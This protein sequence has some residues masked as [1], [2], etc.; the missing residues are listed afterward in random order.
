M[1]AEVTLRVTTHAAYL[2]TIQMAILV[3]LFKMASY[4]GDSYI[5]HMLILRISKQGSGEKK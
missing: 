2:F 1:Y 5:K 4:Y 3:I